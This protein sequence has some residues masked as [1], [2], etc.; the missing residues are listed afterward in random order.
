MISVLVIVGLFTAAAIA[1]WCVVPKT[2]GDL[3]KFGVDLTVICPKTMREHAFGEW[4][5]FAQVSKRRTCT[6][7]GKPEY[8]INGRYVR[9]GRHIRV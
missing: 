7:C 9:D 6:V 4:E 8:F 1:I 3:E 2:Y 5:P